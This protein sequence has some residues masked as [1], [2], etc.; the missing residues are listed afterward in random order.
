MLAK[1]QR[2]T[3]RFDQACKQLVSNMHACAWCGRVALGGP[4][5]SLRRYMV[6]RRIHPAQGS[7]APPIPMAVLANPPLMPLAR[8]DKGQGW[9]WSCQSCGKQGKQEEAAAKRRNSQ[10]RMQVPVGTNAAEMRRWVQM[11]SILYR[12]PPGVA[13]DLSVVRCGVQYSKDMLGYVHALDPTSKPSLL[14]GPLINWAV[15][16]VNKQ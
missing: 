13:G 7:I 10:A 1:C 4:F 6:A 8:H 2:H 16:Q 5:C 14:S 11:M 9:W 3:Q 12:L 15:D